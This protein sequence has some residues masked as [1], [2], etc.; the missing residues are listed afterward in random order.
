MSPRPSTPSSAL[1]HV[2]EVI[3]LEADESFPAR[4]A[5]RRP[6][7]VFN[8]AE[9]LYGPNRESHVPA[10][11]EF[12]GIPYHASDPL[13]LALTLHK[14]RAKEILAYYGVPTAPF[15]V[16]N[17]RA[18]ARNV[19]AA[20]PALRQAG[21]GGIGQGH[22]REVPLHQPGRAGAA[23][24]RPARDLSGAGADRELAAGPG[25]HRRHPG[26]RREA[27]CL[28]H[29]RDALGG[30]AA[31]RQPIYGYEAKWLWDTPEHPL[32]LFECP[33]DISEELAQDIRSA[34]LG[35]YRVLG[36]RDWCRVD[37]RCDAAGRPMVVELNPLPGILPDPQDNSC[38][39]KAARAAGM[40]YDDLIQTVADIAWRRISGRSLLAEDGLREESRSCS[41]GAART[42]AR[43]TSPR[44]WPTSTRSATSSGGG[45]TR[46]TLLPV[47]LGDVRWLPRVPRRPGLQ[48]LR[49]DQRPRPVRGLVVG[50]LELTGVPF[51]GCRSWPVTI[52]HRKH[53]ANTLLAAAGVPVPPS[54]W[55]GNKT[56]DRFPLPV[57]VKPSAEDASVGIDAGAV[58]TTQGR[59]SGR[60][61]QIC[62]QWDEV[63]VQEYVAGPRGQRGVRRQGILPISEILFDG[64]PRAPG[65]S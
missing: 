40:S 20:L 34:A 5:L 55:R 62:E 10:I 29:R 50:A 35:A 14:G 6:D 63:L 51:T 4:L 65:P 28:P 42:G 58:C 19:N 15:V 12:L 60:L 56:A 36:C 47:H 48:P 49:G 32:D 7:F 43:R 37:V 8:I 44:S 33:A 31:G 16:A 38:F 17:T 3:R 9:G 1:S 26:Q 22:H 18:D 53:I 52:C 23:G 24:R 57:I 13:T 39:P 54:C 27:R 21:A 2:G 11:C 30:A 45:G 41:T 61:A 59:S 25:V 64:C 46:S